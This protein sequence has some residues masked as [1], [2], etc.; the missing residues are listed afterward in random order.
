MCLCPSSQAPLS[1]SQSDFLKSFC[2]SH[3]PAFCLSSPQPVSFAVYQPT[4]ASEQDLLSFW[5]IPEFKSWFIPLDSLSIQTILGFLNHQA[6]RWIFQARLWSNFKLILWNFY[7]CQS[8]SESLRFKLNT[9]GVKNHWSLWLPCWTPS[10]FVFNLTLLK[11][12]F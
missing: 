8:N 2:A 12:I 1:D 3:C 9:W 6:H 5:A 10:S 11:E 7:C 4:L